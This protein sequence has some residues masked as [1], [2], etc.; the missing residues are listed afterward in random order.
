VALSIFKTAVTLCLAVW[1]LQALAL[2]I[3]A[4]STGRSGACA[5]C[6]GQ[7]RRQCRQLHGPQGA[8]S[9]V[10]KLYRR[11]ATTGSGRWISDREC[12]N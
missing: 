4:A 12:L 2:Q 6:V 7:V 5:R 10:F 9:S 3:T 8:A 11:P 1:G